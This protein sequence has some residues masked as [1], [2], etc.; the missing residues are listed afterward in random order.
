VSTGERLLF[1]SGLT[2]SL[3][4]GVPI[5]EDVDISVRRGEILGLV[6]ESGSGKS[7]LALA[8][9]GFTRPGARIVKGEVIVGDQ[10]MVGRPEREL[11]RRRGRLVSYVPQDPQSS[12][13]PGRRIVDQLHD[14]IC[15]RDKHDWPRLVH[16][17]LE[18][19][20]LP[21][22]DEFLARFP[23]QL[24]GGQQQRA[25]IAMAIVGEPSLVVLD[26]PTTGLDV[27]TQAGLLRE[28]VRLRDS[29]EIGVVYVTHDVAAVA[30]IADSVAV[31][32]A[33]RIVEQGGA[34]ELLR[35]PYH[36]YTVGLLESVPDHTRPVHLKG[37]PGVAVGVGEW[38]SG[39]AFA[40]RC[41]QADPEC[42]ARLP[43]LEESSVPGH[44]VRCIHWRHTPQPLYLGDSRA[45]VAAGAQ[46][47]LTVSGL[48]A[49]YRSRRSEVVAAED[50]SFTV[51]PGEC[52]A[53]V[54]ES[55]SGKT[56]VA[57]CIAGLHVPA[58]G[59]IRLGDT[60]L[61]PQAAKRSREARR[62]LQFIFQN[63]YESLNPRHRVESS[64]VGAAMILRQLPREQARAEAAR[65][66]E[67]VRLPARIAT[68]FPA[69]LS[70]GE[71]QRVAIA[72]A[73]V[74]E[75]DLLVCD[76]I[77]SSLD[78]SVQAAILE[79]LDNLRKRHGLA[80]LFITHDLGVVASTADRVIVLNKGRIC[81]T[82]GIPDVLVNPSHSYTKLLLSS[83]PQ[84]TPG[85]VTVQSTSVSTG[86]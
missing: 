32:Y 67:E 45:Q 70:G 44:L 74:A 21:D 36:P 30:S 23:H 41:S 50:V 86:Y 58:A 4:S 35:R 6:G 28:I 55:G 73:L 62:R 5:I 52:L 17:A 82:G 34:A 14:R 27:V 7:T 84:L 13:N 69:E 66:L 18:R 76:E 37:L 75:P 8:T 26:E 57:R 16:A 53:L 83:A 39:C 78:V 65:A 68:R 51:A 79:L 24:S 71:R 3:T 85:T 25:L 11:R 59:S 15:D 72:R 80:M 49:T 63:P 60:E 42:L 2:V 54:G 29:L 9:L 33:G 64:I 1:V 43:L 40:P 10:P 19:A 48:R 77:T 47:V 20:Q 81:E 22:T 38:P 12:L 46:P 56:T 61:A 31:M